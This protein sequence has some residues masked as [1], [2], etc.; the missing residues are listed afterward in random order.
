MAKWGSGKLG[1]ATGGR[2]RQPGIEPLTRS[3]ASHLGKLLGQT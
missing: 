2:P 1:D 3:L